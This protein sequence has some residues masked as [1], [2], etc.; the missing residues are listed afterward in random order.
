MSARNTRRDKSEQAEQSEQSEQSPQDETISTTSN[1][2]MPGF[3]EKQNNHLKQSMKK[4]QQDLTYVIVE[5]PRSP[6]LEQKIVS[7]PR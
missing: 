2:I 7:L 4:V 3:T 5:A 6:K 1:F